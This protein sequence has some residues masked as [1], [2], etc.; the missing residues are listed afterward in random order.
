LTPF[1]FPQIIHV[2][3]APPLLGLLKEVLVG[4][5]SQH[6]S[7]VPHNTPPPKHTQSMGEP[8]HEPKPKIL[9]AWIGEGFFIFH[10][11]NVAKIFT[12]G[13]YT[14]KGC[15]LIKLVNPKY[16]FISFHSWFFIEN[17]GNS[18]LDLF[19]NLSFAKKKKGYFLALILWSRLWRWP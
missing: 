9:I 13:L 18:Q 8:Y 15:W 3:K 19:S 1:P 14:T 7:N 17:L 2:W 12:R 5:H 6:V 11:W 16:L 10:M 4:G